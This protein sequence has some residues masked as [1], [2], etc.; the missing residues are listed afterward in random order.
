MIGNAGRQQLVTLLPSPKTTCPIS[1][2][3]HRYHTLRI[4]TGGAIFPRARV[5]SCSI[6]NWGGANRGGI[7]DEKE[8]EQTVCRARGV[9][10][11]PS[12]LEGGGDLAGWSTR[13]E[14]SPRPHMYCIVHTYMVWYIT[15]SGHGCTAQGHLCQD[16]TA[17][18][19]CMYVRY[20]DIIVRPGRWGSTKTP[21]SP[22]P[23]RPCAGQD[24]TSG[25]SR[26]NN[27]RVIRVSAAWPAGKMPRGV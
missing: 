5:S 14:Q 19:I 9:W 20:C 2:N 6:A 16:C 13:V 10:G 4:T 3:T 12:R 27:A 11:V 1:I 22:P 18:H 17:Y 24:A 15:W 23:P 26:I 25:F 21:P 8:K 7:R